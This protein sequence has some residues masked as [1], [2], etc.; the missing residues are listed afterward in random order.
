MKLGPQEAAL[1]QQPAAP[2]ASA[3]PQGGPG[4]PISLCSVWQMFPC[5]GNRK[6]SPGISW[7][8]SGFPLLPDSGGHFPRRAWGLLPLCVGL[9][10]GVG[11]GGPGS[12]I[13][14]SEALGDALTHLRGLPSVQNSGAT[15]PAAPQG[16]GVVWK[17][18]FD[19]R[20]LTQEGSCEGDSG[21]KRSLS[22]LTPLPQTCPPSLCP[23]GEHQDCPLL[24][25]RHP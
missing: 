3:G 14:G 21:F 1:P 11:S 25:L 17:G 9:S 19:L 2:M 7:T 10:P 16:W 23:F 8:G 13:S 20:V 6:R 12:V 15:G 24:G 5:V 18:S 4:G 22:S